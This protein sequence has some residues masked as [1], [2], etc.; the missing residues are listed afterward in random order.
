MSLRKSL[1]LAL[2]LAVVA[3]LIFKVLLPHEESKERAG[4]SLGGKGEGAIEKITVQNGTGT[5]TLENKEIVP[6]QLVALDG[7]S[8]TLTTERASKWVLAGVEMGAVERA[9]LNALLTTLVNLK[10]DTPIPAEEVEADRSMYGIAKESPRIAVTVQGNETVFRLGKKNEYLSKRYVEVGEGGPLYLVP[11]TLYE[12][13]SK[14][15]LDMRDRTPFE[16]LSNDVQRLSIER[17]GSTVAVEKDAAAGWRIKQPGGFTASGE[18]VGTLLRELRTMR[19][20]EFVEQG[21]SRLAEFGLD[22]PFAKVTVL[23]GGEPTTP[24]VVL[25]SRRAPAG[26][27]TNL[28][29][30]VLRE[31]ASTI[32]RIDG[33]DPIPHVV[34]TVDELRE[35]QLF[36]FP[37]D[38][39][40]KVTYTESGVTPLLLQRTGS[41]WS[42]NGKPGDA[43]FIREALRRLS[44]VSASEFPREGKSF[45]FDAP[46]VLIELEFAPQEGT[47][48]TRKMVVGDA[49]VRA[50]GTKLHYAGVDALEEPF[51]LTE[52]ALREVLP[53]VEAL[54]KPET[55]PTPTDETP[56]PSNPTPAP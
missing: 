46:R 51:L 1:F 48:S 41:E 38:L 40:S 21:G 26:E 44:D 50:D 27:P 32:L 52:K 34:K 14:S 25:L 42:V 6:G 23:T 9:S 43:P 16:T 20:A 17:D 8:D 53:K 11:E 18:K 24:F 47:P 3:F 49:V 35:T 13:A 29:T 33:R 56:E 5:Y 7:S 36:R 4:F 45:G 19:V 12:A 28:S 55:T 15:Q 54:L 31:G 22:T 37:I 30:Y 10:L 2:L 39:V